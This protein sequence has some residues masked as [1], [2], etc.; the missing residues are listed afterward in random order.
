[1]PSDYSNVMLVFSHQISKYSDHREIV[2]E[3][4]ME[5]I[6]IMAKTSKET[7]NNLFPTLMHYLVDPPD[8]ALATIAQGMYVWR[9]W[10]MKI[11]THPHF[12]TRKAISLSGF[13]FV[14]HGKEAE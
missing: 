14:S 8:Y 12:R 10:N 9:T 5:A 3:T 11:N 1:M 7:Q 6:D 2:R 13:A 4:T